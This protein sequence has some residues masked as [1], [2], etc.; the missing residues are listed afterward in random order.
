MFKLLFF[1]KYF[2]NNI[3]TKFILEYENTDLINKINQINISKNVNYYHIMK[4]NFYI[5]TG[6]NIKFKILF[7]FH[8]F[9]LLQFFYF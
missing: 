6:E 9:L 1:N 4:Q 2:P 8:L 5:L 3:I 7:L